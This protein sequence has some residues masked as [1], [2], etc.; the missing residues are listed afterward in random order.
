LIYHFL[1]FLSLQ[2]EIDAFS[3]LFALLESA[4]ICM[5]VMV[6]NYSLSFFLIVSKG[7]AV[8]E[9]LADQDSSASLLRILKL[10]IINDVGSSFLHSLSN[11]SIFPRTD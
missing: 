9:L 10:A 5:V 7:A 3:V 6:K 11:N 8:F 2:R 4:Y 1:P